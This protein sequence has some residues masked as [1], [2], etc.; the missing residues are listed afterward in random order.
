[1]FLGVESAAW[2]QCEEKRIAV[3]DESLNSAQM[4][5][6]TGERLILLVF[7]ADQDERR[8]IA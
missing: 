4:R 6:A 1:L 3:F 5:T 7:A 8:A 2:S